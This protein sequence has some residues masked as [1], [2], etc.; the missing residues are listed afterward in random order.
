MRRREFIVS[1]L[2]VGAT[3]ATPSR[4]AT[5]SIQYSVAV[6]PPDRGLSGGQ[7]ML[8]T[9]VQFIDKAD[10]EQKYRD[11]LLNFKNDNPSVD[12]TDPSSF[13]VVAKPKHEPGAFEVAD[14]LCQCGHEGSCGG[15]GGGTKAKAQA[16]S[17]S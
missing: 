6:L 2:A 16:K 7:V 14:C 9:T 10:I 1:T 12:L 11:V 17:K 5:P 13:V 15:S 8:D 4:A 3:A